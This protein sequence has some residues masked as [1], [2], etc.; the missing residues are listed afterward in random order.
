MDN[1]VAAMNDLLLQIK[2][3][4]Q[5]YNFIY[6]KHTKENDEIIGGAD[7]VLKECADSDE[8]DNWL[9]VYSCPNIV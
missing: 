1:V 5:L 2:F 8:N 3:L 9:S 4:F 6:T 7:G